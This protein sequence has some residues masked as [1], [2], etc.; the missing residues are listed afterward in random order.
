MHLVSFLFYYSNLLV[1]VASGRHK[2]ANSLSPNWR[3]QQWKHQK[4]AGRYANYFKA[5]K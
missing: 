1:N 2:T 5:V 3:W 4:K